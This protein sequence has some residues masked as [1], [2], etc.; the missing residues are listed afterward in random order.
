VI[1]I[2]VKVIGLNKDYFARRACWFSLSG[3]SA[4]RE[5]KETYSATFASRAQRAVKL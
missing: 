5:K 2:F 1:N 3:L 4:E